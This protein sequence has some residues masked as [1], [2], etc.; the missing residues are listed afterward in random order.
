MPPAEQMEQQPP[1]RLR[2]W[3]VA[4]L[5]EPHGIDAAAMVSEPRL[6][7]RTRRRIEPV[8]RIHHGV[9]APALRRGCRPPTMAMA[10]CVLPVPVRH[11][12]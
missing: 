9:E 3:Q 7:F 6:A 12:R 8:H 11:A 4:G 5:V 2:E 1:A 10:R